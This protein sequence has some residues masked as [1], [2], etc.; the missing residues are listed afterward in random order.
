MVALGVLL[1]LLVQEIWPEEIDGLTQGIKS[2]TLGVL[3]ASP[4]GSPVIQ[5]GQKSASPDLAVPT[6]YLVPIPTPNQVVPTRTPVLPATPV[7]PGLAIVKPTQTPD[8]QPTPTSRPGN[9][10]TPLVQRQV[11]KEWIEALESEV[12]RLTNE[13]RVQHSVGALSY[14]SSLASIARVHSGDM[15]QLDYFAHENLQGQSPSD[16]A[17][18]AGYGCRKDY[19]SYYSEGIAENIFQT[20]LYSSYTTTP[21]GL[22]VSR[23]YMTLEEIATQIVDGWMGSPGH[24]ENILDSKYDKEGI[25]VVVSADEKVYV[26][27]NFC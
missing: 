25:G 27:Q 22:V 11:T 17:A 15:A 6:P 23:D 8:P 1:T 16:R 18:Q 4:T 19:G 9:T 20:S 5:D 2:R 26:T 14:D 10:P 7:R 24:R 12:H 13:E 3:D 21:G